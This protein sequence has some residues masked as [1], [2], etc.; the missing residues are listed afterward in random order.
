MQRSL[1]RLLLAFDSRTFQQY[2]IEPE[3]YS[4]KFL[5]IWLQLRKEV[6]KLSLVFKLPK[7]RPPLMTR[8]KSWGETIRIH[9]DF[10]F[11]WC[12]IS[13][14]LIINK[15]NNEPCPSSKTTIVDSWIANEFLSRVQYSIKSRLDD[16][17]DRWLNMFRWTE[18]TYIVQILRLL[19]CGFC[20]NEGIR[21]VNRFGSLRI[22]SIG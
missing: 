10:N 20:F 7:M 8:A 6:K 22:K 3:T 15:E 12:F 19:L 1:G 16:L 4:V 21:I 11:I 17:K 18:R 14:P 5:M 13:H 9:D 2:Q